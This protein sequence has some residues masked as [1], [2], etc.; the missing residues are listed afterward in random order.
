MKS[1]DEGEESEDDKI[2]MADLD[3]DV[4]NRFDALENTNKSIMYD[5][6]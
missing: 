5:N 6:L 3:E 2:Q 4:I 1:L